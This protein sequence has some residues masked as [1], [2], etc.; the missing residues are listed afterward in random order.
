MTRPLRVLCAL[1]AIFAALCLSVAQAAG[2]DDVL[3]PVPQRS[4]I[5][6]TV[7]GPS[8]CGPASLAMALEAFGDKVPTADLRKRANQL[9]GVSSPDTGTKI[10]HLAKI[11]E[12]QGFAVSGPMDG[13]KYRRWTV[14]QAR[15]ELRAGNPVLVQVYF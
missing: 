14:D 4:Q 11:A 1:A 12:E 5:D 9:L 6:G 2:P 3:L 7:W 13:K 8:N 10:E 15:A